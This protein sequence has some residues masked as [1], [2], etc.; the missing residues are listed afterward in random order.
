MILISNARTKAI[1]IIMAK[2]T[3]ARFQKTFIKKKEDVQRNWF[4]LNAKGK[5]LG[6][7]ASEIAKVLRGKH[8]PDYTPHVDSGDGVIVVNAD[9]VKISGN[10]EAQKEYVR[11][12]GYIGGLRKTSYREMMERHPERILMHAVKGMVPKTRQGRKQMTRLRIFAGEQ[13]G[14]EAQ[15]PIAVTI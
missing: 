1:R 12:T 5:T 4:I 8:K 3:R 6:R 14:L 13:H 11:Y 15:N 10:K 9:Q 2:K 7:L